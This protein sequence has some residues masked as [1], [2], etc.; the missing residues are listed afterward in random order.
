MAGLGQCVLTIIP[1][2]VPATQ[3]QAWSGRRHGQA[4]VGGWGHRG[5]LSAVAVC[6]RHTLC[7][8]EFQATPH[9]HL[10]ELAGGQLSGSRPVQQ[11]TCPP[12]RLTV[13]PP[14]K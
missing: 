12:A 13:A 8:S 6:D 9:T 10:T 11:V 4:G 7:P 5:C 3:E 2:G 14:G 1:H